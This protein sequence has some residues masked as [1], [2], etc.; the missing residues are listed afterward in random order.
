MGKGQ[1]GLQA[2]VTTLTAANNLEANGYNYYGAVGTA[3]AQF[4]F[5]NPGKISGTFTWLDSYINQIWLNN[6]FQ[7]ALMELLT[8]TKSIPYSAAG[9]SLIE[10]ALLSPIN[11]GLNF[12]AFRAGVSLSNQQIAEVNNAAG[13]NIA[14]TLQN[15]GWYL[16][17]LSATAQTRSQRGSPPITFWYVDGE[18]VQSINM[19]SIVVL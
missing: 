6:Q 14:P 17:I 3:N 2:G 11:A 8:N 19:A 7:L 1:A 12:G 4:R 13:L 18:S 9:Y 10:A 16:Q 15:Q 5:Y